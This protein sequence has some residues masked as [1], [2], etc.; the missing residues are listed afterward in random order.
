[1]AIVAALIGLIVSLVTPVISRI[2]A[3]AEDRAM[4]AE[5]NSIYKAVVVFRNENGRFPTTYEELRR[6]IDVANFEAK[7]KLNSTPPQG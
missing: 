2:R 3:N 5:M 1:M 4:E 6:Y 7:Y